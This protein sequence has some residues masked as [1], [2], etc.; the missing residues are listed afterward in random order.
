[1]GL[2]ASIPSLQ[3]YPRRLFHGM[4]D[5]NFAIPHQPDTPAK[6]SPAPTNPGMM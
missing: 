2:V 1:V 5:S 3:D 4:T 6:I